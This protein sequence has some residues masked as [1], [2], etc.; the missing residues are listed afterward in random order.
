V[1]EFDGMRGLGAVEGD[2]GTSHDF[3][4]TRIADGTRTVRVGARVRYEIVPGSL[5]R[6]EAADIEVISA[7]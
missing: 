5:G 1:V 6:W 2:D 3:H 7:R 4:C